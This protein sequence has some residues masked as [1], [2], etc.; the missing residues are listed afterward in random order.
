MCFNVR[1][2][3]YNVDSVLA[4]VA[5]GYVADTYDFGAGFLK[6]YCIVCS[7]VTEALYNNC[8]CF[9]VD[10]LCFEEFK[11]TRCNAETCRCRTAL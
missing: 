5:A 4:V 1:L 3:C 10:I 9:G 11:D 6:E 8:C 7:D 2:S